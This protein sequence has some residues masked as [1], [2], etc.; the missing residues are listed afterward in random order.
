MMQDKVSLQELK[1]KYEGIAHTKMGNT[2]LIYHNQGLTPFFN[3]LCDVIANVADITAIRPTYIALYTLET[4]SKVINETSW[5]NICSPNS[6]G[7]KNLVRVSPYLAI[8]SLNSTTTDTGE[9]K[10]VL[11]AKIPV[12]HI[13]ARTIYIMAVFPGTINQN[14]TDQEDKA[15][16]YYKMQKMSDGVMTWEPIDLAVGVYGD[17]LAL[18]WAMCFN[19]MTTF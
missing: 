12:V 13:T 16:A 5:T 19:N 10:L 17:V 2:E 4:P 1:I 14:G 8:N 15:L 18:D 6:S 7:Q 3:S 9:K 11:Q